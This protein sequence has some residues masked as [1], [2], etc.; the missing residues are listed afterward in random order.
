ML[1]S[2]PLGFHVPVEAMQR[3]EAVPARDE[4]NNRETEA[5][6]FGKLSGKRALMILDRVFNFELTL[7]EIDGNNREKVPCNAKDHKQ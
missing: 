3:Y 7:I 2:G 5:S 1:R 4:E 6:V